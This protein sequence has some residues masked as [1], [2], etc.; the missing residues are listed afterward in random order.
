MAPDNRYKEVRCDRCRK[1][2]VC[3]PEQDFY[4]TGVENKGVCEP[5]LL[6]AN[7]LTRV[8]IF[9]SETMSLGDL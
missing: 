3:T 8:V 7:G 4:P 5:C 1:V 6:A 9:D 2:Y